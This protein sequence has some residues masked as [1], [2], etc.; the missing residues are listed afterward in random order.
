MSLGQDFEINQVI[1]EDKCMS[2]APVD[3]RWFEVN[4]VILKEILKMPGLYC[5][6]PVFRRLLSTSL[7]CIYGSPFLCRSDSAILTFFV[8]LAKCCHGLRVYTF[9]RSLNCPIR[10]EWGRSP[11][12]C[13]WVGHSASRLLKICDH[14][15]H[16]SNFGSSARIF[17][18]CTLQPHP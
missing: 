18:G 14:N 12:K 17:C 15:K 5:K 13:S 9:R 16:L 3:R 6:M 8:S 2:L 1:G 11:V 10:Y 4:D 7:F